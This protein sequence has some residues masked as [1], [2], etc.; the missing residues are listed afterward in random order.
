MAIIKVNP[1]DVEQFTVVTTPRRNYVSSSSG[2]TG[3]VNVFPRLSTLEKETSFETYVDADKVSDVDF[4]TS[5][6]ACVMQAASDRAV[7][8]QITETIDSYFNLVSSAALKR[9]REIE[10]ERFTPTTKLTQYSV[11]KNNVKDML[12]SYYRTSYPDSNWA[13]TNYNSLNF[14]TA[15]SD[16][17]SMPTGS[18]ILYPNLPLSG[19]EYPVWQHSGSYCLSGAFS[20][21]FHINP[22]YTSN[23]SID[24]FGPGTIFHLSSSYSLSLVTGSAKNINGL[25][26][27]FRL[28][29][30]LSHS[31]DIPPS[32]A[33]QGPMPQD[34]VF[35]SDDNCI[36]WN[37]WHH[38]VVR[39]GTDK[40][41]DGT[42]SFVIDGVTKGTF[43]VPSSSIALT[44]G[45]NDPRVLCIGN[46][47]EGNNSGLSSQEYFFSEDLSSYDGVDQLT[48]L[49]SISHDGP[50]NFLFRHP[51]K[52]EVHNLSIRRSYLSDSDISVSSSYGLSLI[53]SND[54]AFYLPPFFVEETNIRRTS[55]AGSPDPAK[56][57]DRGGVIQTPFF[58]IDGTTDDPFNVAMAFEEEQNA[59]VVWHDPPVFER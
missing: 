2:V 6:T 7:G 50:E 49:T 5:Y 54:V 45:S 21:D 16:G 32:Q 10:V 43:V 12:M 26:A 4:N 39:W 51:L 22:R 25:P 30:Q 56:A 17:F 19:V 28:Q 31:A 34:L 59:R 13:Y 37:N 40:I 55:T 1:D 36:K 8:H 42:G 38:V 18:V 48:S 44:T 9:T 29:L 20:F 14:F 52:A 11:S 58:A 27:A 47:Y 24:Q 53:N 3:S 35:L 23:E 57:G 15:D 41:N 46:F 33:L